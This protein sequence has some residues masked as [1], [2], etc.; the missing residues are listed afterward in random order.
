MASGINT[1]FRQVGIATGI[2]A[3]GAVFQARVESKLDTLLAGT[4]A[5]SR[6][7]ELSEAIASG[8]AQQAIGG[9]PPG[10]RPRIEAAANEA[11]VSGLN[12][13]L[14]VAAGIAFVGVIA[15]LAL[16][17]QRDFV[18]APGGAPEEAPAAA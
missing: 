17:R 10:V 7:H 18:A 3:L 8:G 13:I 9:A 15:A 12:D 14:L 4:P 6:T 2:A 1:T 5:A 16:V 11:F